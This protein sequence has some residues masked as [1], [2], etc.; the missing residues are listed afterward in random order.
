MR[1]VAGHFVF[2]SELLFLEAVE[3]VF[4]G[5]GSV[6]FLFDQGMKRGMLR[7]EFLDHC[8]V[9]WCRSFQASVTTA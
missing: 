4:V 1:E 7:L 9:H 3:K 5:V 8:L 6:L 2:Q